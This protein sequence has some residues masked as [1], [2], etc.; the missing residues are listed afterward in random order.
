MVTQRTLNK[1]ERM[2]DENQHLEVRFEIARYFDKHYGSVFHG[3]VYFFKHVIS[4]RDRFNSM[5]IEL[6]YLKEDMLDEMFKDAGFYASADEL[7][8][9]H[10]CL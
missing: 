9:I 5:P 1:W 7:Y 10:K 8:K 4:I 3:Y 2:T 6:S